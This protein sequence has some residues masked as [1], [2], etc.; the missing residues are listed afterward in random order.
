MERLDSKNF[1]FLSNLSTN[2]VQ[3]PISTHNSVQQQTN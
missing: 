1:D 3:L 2:Y